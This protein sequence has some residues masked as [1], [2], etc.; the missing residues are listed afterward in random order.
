M[1]LNAL[2]RVF[3]VLY[4]VEAGLFLLLAPWS[5]GWDR[6]VLHIPVAALRSL[7]LLPVLRGAMSG[8]GLVHLLWSVHDVQ[9]L[10]VRWRLRAGISS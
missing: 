7:F 8:F 10:I 3:F 9:E 4:C 2:F 1:R 6:A 5:S